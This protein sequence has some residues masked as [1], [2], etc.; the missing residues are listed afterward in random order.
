MVRRLS[1]VAVLAACAWAISGGTAHANTST[2]WC[3]GHPS[4]KTCVLSATYDGT[5]FTGDDSRFDV[6]AT[7]GTVSGAKIVLWNVY[8]TPPATDLS[9]EAGHTFSV[10]I[11]TNVVPR[12]TD[13]YGAAETITRTGPTNGEYEVTITGQPVSVSD[14]TQE[15]CSFPP[16]GP[17]CTPVSPQNSSWIFQGEVDDYGYRG[18]STALTDSFA[19]MD[20]YTNVIETSLPPEL[21]EVNGVNELEIQLTDHHLEHDGTTQVKGDFYLRIP[22]AFLATYWGINDPTTLATDG[23]NASIGAGGGTLSVTVEPGN[24][25]VDVQI[26]GMTFSRRKLLVKLGHVTPRAPTH[27]KATRTGGTTAKVTFTKSKARGQRV[28]G[29]K[30]SCKAGN[31]TSVTA[32]SRRSPLLVKSLVSGQAYKCTV[33]GHS[34]AGYGRPSSKFSIRS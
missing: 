1:V 6:F 3:A 14:G 17:T 34:K 7:A 13:G 16:S 10:T 19:G 32:K 26:S 23:L 11:Q 18:Y 33:S 30:L 31:G 2:Y 29:Y 12:E 22:A 4:L 27:I 8:A 21:M 24:T 15:G 9:A 25:A 5:P 28:N 20:M